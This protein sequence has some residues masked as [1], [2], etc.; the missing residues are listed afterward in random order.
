LTPRKEQRENAC[1]ADPDQRSGH[2]SA[3]IVCNV[4]PG[5]NGNP[6]DA[7][8]RFLRQM[9]VKE[10]RSYREWTKT[11]QQRL[12]DLMRHL[13]S[14]DGLLAVSRPVTCLSVEDRFI[15]WPNWALSS[16]ID[17]RLTKP[18]RLLLGQPRLRF[19]R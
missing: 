2:H 16:A 19:I 12:L 8:L 4:T 1:Y 5:L 7:C 3:Q 9:G 6:R 13:L 10:R 18:G 11:E 17:P 15:R 14:Y